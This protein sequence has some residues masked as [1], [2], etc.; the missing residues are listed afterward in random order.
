MVNFSKDDDVDVDVYEQRLN[1]S[2]EIYMNLKSVARYILNQENLS[3][4]LYRLCRRHMNMSSRYG[5]GSVEKNSVIAYLKNSEHIPAERFRKKGVQGESLDKDKVLKPLRDSGIAKDFLDLYMEFQECST[6]G[7]NV[8]K[9]LSRIKNN[10]TIE[11]WNS[12][13]VCVPFS[14][15]R[16]L[17]LRFNYS[18]EGIIN[19]PKDMKD[20]IFAPQDYYLVW[21]DFSQI[22]ARVAYNTLL[23]DET[24][25]EFIRKFPDDIYAG[26]ANW[27][28][29]FQR[30]ILA[31]NISHL[32]AVCENE[33]K[34]H[35]TAYSY[36]KLEEAR[37]RLDNWKVFNGFSDK[38]E[39]TLYK[40]Y[41]LQTIYGTRF[42]LNPE[43]NIFIKTL[44]TVLDSCPKY[45]RY[46]NDI[47]K[48][49][50]LG[51]PI[52]V[53]CYF[54]HMELVPAVGGRRV[55]DTLFKCLN[56]P[57]QGTSSEILILTINNILDRLYDLGYTEEQARVYYVRHDEPIFLIH[58]DVMKDAHIFKEFETINIDNWLPLE[59]GF[60]FGR[61]YGRVS[62]DVQ[63]EYNKIKIISDNTLDVTSKEVV[64]HYPLEPMLELGVSI[65]RENGH[66]IIAFYNG[67]D[68]SY[69]TM[70]RNNVDATV[71]DIII[72]KAYIE[73][74]IE[75]VK[76]L[77]YKLVVIYNAINYYGDDF[78]N[79]I[80]VIYSPLLQP[81]IMNARNIAIASM[82]NH[83]GNKPR[84]LDNADFL[85]SL[86][87]LNVFKVN[88][89]KVV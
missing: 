62:E 27:V 22:D 19:F 63:T 80:S 56:Y 37:D 46:W 79:G 49:A 21:G 8:S 81:S 38:K 24:N 64:D 25:F 30:N 36:G 76:P 57:V 60:N 7:N 23:R 74:Y 4:T 44:G 54:S 39:R 34:L 89:E 14:A 5:Y 41:C 10:E 73:K 45:N 2:G 32:E 29:E 55:N 83:L 43:A 20:V 86:V 84:S 50:D 71:E 6:R 1:Y 48:R 69:D 77:G 31:Q 26:F 67:E 28:N 65:F 59:L 12:D 58:K 47:K 9:L 17:N 3:K 68:N 15:N 42:H 72:I 85:S 82:D 88:D 35:G 66:M 75:N 18:R 11:G 53:N 87:R 13:L 33:N 52:K 16:S 70:Y 40:V 61:C 51:I 78:I